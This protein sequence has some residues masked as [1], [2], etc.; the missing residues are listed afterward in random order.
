MQVRLR[1]RIEWTFLCLFH[2]TGYVQIYLINLRLRTSENR[3]T[4]FC[5][6][7]PDVRS[8][9]SSRRSMTLQ[10]C[11]PLWQSH[12]EDHEIS[13]ENIAYGSL[14]QFIVFDFFF[15]HCKWWPYWNHSRCLSL[16][17]AVGYHGCRNYNTPPPRLMRAQGFQRYPLRI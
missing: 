17:W 10:L 1:S 7:G 13:G 4:L 14:Y 6:T 2:R 12:W 5:A 3:H 8:L 11:D 9:Q 16:Y 15:P